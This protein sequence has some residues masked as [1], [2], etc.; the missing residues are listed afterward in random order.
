DIRM[1]HAGRRAGLPQCPLA[2]FQALVVG[3]SERQRDFLDRHVATE[4]L[5]AGQPDPSHPAGANRSTEPVA[6]RDA[7]ILNGHTVT[8]PAPD[9]GSI[10]GYPTRAC[11]SHIRTGLIL[12]P[13]SGRLLPLEPFDRLLR[14]LDDSGP[15]GVRPPLIAAGSG[16]R[17]LS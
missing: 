13:R 6:T 17:I 1:V 10:R 8:S 15:P 3:Q 9:G 12:G 14:F 7:N 4:N 5:V 16:L 2:Q 11:S